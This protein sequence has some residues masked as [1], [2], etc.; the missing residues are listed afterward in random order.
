MR[1]IF[2][3]LTLL[4]LKRVSSQNPWQP[5]S[6]GVNNG[7]GFP[8]VTAFTIYN[9][10]LIVGGGFSNAGGNAANKIAAW[11]GANWSTLS[12]GIQGSLIAC[13]AGVNVLQVY[14]GNLIAGGLYTFANNISDNFIYKWNGSAWS[15]LSNKLVTNVAG[16]ASI[17]A[18]T[19]YNNK[20]IVAGR[21]DT[22]NGVAA[23]NIAQWNGTTWS[24][25]GSG[26]PSTSFGTIE[27]LTV[28]NNELYAGG[29][30]T[31]VA[32]GNIV[33][34][35]IANKVYEKYQNL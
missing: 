12:N 6:T 16:L 5:L 18:M 7:I 33:A 17:K 1:K 25:L 13:E 21:F 30:F 15:S 20:L 14:Q 8:P 4:T 19:V 34:N 27:S 32:S 31:F 24:S 10:K 9:N 23:I 11:D 26:G 2:I 22:I 35:N 3:L 28:F 29:S